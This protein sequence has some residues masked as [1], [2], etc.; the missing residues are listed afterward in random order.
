[1]IAWIIR[2]V[3]TRP[4][5]WNL[6]IFSP[7]SISFKTRGDDPGG[8]RIL[9][10]FHDITGSVLLETILNLDSITKELVQLGLYFGYVLGDTPTQKTSLYMYGFFGAMNITIPTEWL[11]IASEGSKCHANLASLMKL[12][13][14]NTMNQWG[15][16]QNIMP[17]EREKNIQLWLHMFSRVFFSWFWHL[18]FQKIWLCLKMCGPKTY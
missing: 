12:C 6:M 1:M 7:T 3:G 14:Y 13:V 5:A 9:F 11:F 4:S 2:V 15:R 18:C 8:I 16:Q 10:F 17:K